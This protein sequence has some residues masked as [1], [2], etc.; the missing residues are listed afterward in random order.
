M[1]SKIISIANEK[2]GVGKTTTAI[3]LATVLHKQNYKVLVV[4]FDPQGNATMCLG[5]HNPDKL[6]T[7]I[8]DVILSSIKG[9]QIN[10]SEYILHTN[11]IDLLPTD[12]SLAALETTMQAE[13][14]G[15]YILADI[16]EPLKTSYDYIIIDC[17]PSL[18]ILTINALVASDSVLIPV[19]AH[20]LAVKGL[21]L[22]FPVIQKVKKRLN[23]KLKING[24]LMTMYDKRTK[25]AKEIF[26]QVQ[27]I[28]GEQVVVFKTLIP[29]SIKVSESS[30]AGQAIIDFQS[31]NIVA[32]AYNDFTKEYI[33]GEI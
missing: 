18:G 7:T 27:S 14:G 30:Y 9:N 22:L 12:I 25:F 17:M 8:S 5:F 28:Y 15:E 21:E 20:Y 32:Q 13:T 29:I 2:G 19:Q 1:T 31:D 3:N 26:T 16:L 33:D 11:T 24:I 4:D 23:P 6:E 10:T